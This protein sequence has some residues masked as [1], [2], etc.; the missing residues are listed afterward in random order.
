M[1]PLICA[2]KNG[3][4]NVVISLLNTPGINPDVHRREDGR[5]ALHSA[6]SLDKTVIVALL[7]A[8]GAKKNILD[9]KNQNARQIAK[10]KSVT[11]FQNFIF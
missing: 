4:P 3:D 9:S 10:G 1:T 2:A 11:G 5:T 7:L 8:C 6:S